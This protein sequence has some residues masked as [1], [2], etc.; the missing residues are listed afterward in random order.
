M[1]IT[2]FSINFLVGLV[3]VGIAVIFCMIIG[4][5]TAK[6]TDNKNADIPSSILNGCLFATF[7]VGLILSY[8]A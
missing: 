3:V 8:L 7:S 5:I 4:R 1:N 2:I 6:F